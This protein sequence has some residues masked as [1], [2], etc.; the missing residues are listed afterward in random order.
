MNPLASF[1]QD[2]PDPRRRHLIDHPLMT[3]LTIV[4]L[5]TFCGAEGWDEMVDWAHAK[6][7]WLKT[8]LDMP[9]G[10]SS[11]DTLRRLMAALLPGPFRKAFVAWA[12]ALAEHTQG[13]LVAIDGK[14]ARGSVKD[15]GSMLHVVRAWVAANRLVLGQVA[16]DAKSNEITAIPELLKLLSIQGATVTVDAMGTQREI[17]LTILEKDAH[18]VMSLKDNQPTLH[19]EA[20]EHLGPRPE[21]ARASAS[22]H[23]TVDEGHGRREVRRV[24][25]SSKLDHLATLITWPGVQTLIR[26]ESERTTENGT[27]WENRYYLSSRQLTAKEAADLVRGHWGVE[28]G[29]HWTLDVAFREDDSRIREGHAPENMSLIRSIMLNAFKRDTSRKAGV[30]RKQKMCGWDQDYLLGLVASLF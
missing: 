4:I 8:F 14:A 9:H 23:K 11:A 18:Y 3:L 20:K 24:W 7:A 19:D 2:I 6:E 28:N 22:F 15:D 26:I 13:K 29:C 1:L 25:T 16:C 10:V 30:K 27:S 21:P 12:Q 17:A 5:S